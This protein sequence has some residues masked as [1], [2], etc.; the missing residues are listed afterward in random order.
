MPISVAPGSGPDCQCP[1]CSRR[2]GARRGQKP[3]LTED[4]ARAGRLPVSQ[5]QSHWQLSLPRSCHGLS[6]HSS[7]LP[8]GP[9]PWPRQLTDNAR[10]RRAGHWQSQGR[11][12]DLQSQAAAA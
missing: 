4:V 3:R 6:Q 2:P 8:V 1:G 5:P 10:R 7:S 12:A 11:A 9:R